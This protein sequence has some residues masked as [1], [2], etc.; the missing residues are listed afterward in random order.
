M[1][2]V[3]EVVR[4]KL[5]AGS[6]PISP[7]LDKSSPSSTKP[8]IESR[9]S[10]QQETT[11]TPTPDD[12]R[13]YPNSQVLIL[14]DSMLSGIENHFADSLRVKVVC[15]GGAT[16]DS[17]A[18]KVDEALVGEDPQ[19]IVVHCGTNCVMS[20]TRHDA[21]QGFETLLKRIRW[22]SPNSKILLSGIIHRLDDKSLNGRID[23]LNAALQSFQDSNTIFV[24]HNST[25]KYL[26]KLLSKDGLHLK[27]AGKKLVAA[28]LAIVLRTGMP[29]VTSIR[30]WNS[31][32]LVATP[33]SS[34][35]PPALMDLPPPAPAPPLMN[36]SP[37]PRRNV[38]H[39][40]APERRNFS[41]NKGTKATTRR[42]KK[43]P[44]YK[45]SPRRSYQPDRFPHPVP[46]KSYYD[47][48]SDQTAP[49]STL[50]YPPIGHD[51]LSPQ[52][53]NQQQSATSY[54]MDPSMWQCPSNSIPIHQPNALWPPIMQTCMSDAHRS[55]PPWPQY[56]PRLMYASPWGQM[57]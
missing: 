1:G 41:G 5:L 21:I 24:E 12:L 19:S 17:L 39:A 6:L 38:H 51:Q 8:S 45:S 29:S 56:M 35:T 49:S 9:G 30:T 23:S 3:L 33:P 55:F 32:K 7:D 11:T 50:T 46:E 53:A 26:K 4:E 28:N 54:F 22:N 31:E 2:R 47:H 52:T 44:K 15:L 43:L 42:N 25:I 14:S 37:P 36:S 13:P 18:L 10:S 48:Y 27:L 16:P 34:I 40:L 57:F 20:G